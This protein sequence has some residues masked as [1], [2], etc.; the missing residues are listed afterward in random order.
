MNTNML[1]DG[2]TIYLWLVV[3]A[4]IIVA[5]IFGIRWAFRNEQFDED[6]KYVMFGKED[7]DKMSPE[8]YAKS[9]QV[10]E[11]QIKRRDEVLREQANRH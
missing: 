9:Q 4:L 3:G 8:E 10:L 11:Q 6:I 5:V 7:Q 1:V 2:W